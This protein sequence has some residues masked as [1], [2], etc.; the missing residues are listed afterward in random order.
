MKPE[1]ELEIYDYKKYTIQLFRIYLIHKSRKN[2]LTILCMS[3]FHSSN[4]TLSGES[5]KQNS[6]T[7]I[8]EQQEAPHNPAGKILN[9]WS[10]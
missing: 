7:G 1:D 8:K 3:D 4:Q 6:L 2:K 10:V 9:A 5:E